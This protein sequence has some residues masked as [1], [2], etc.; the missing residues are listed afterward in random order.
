MPTRVLV[1]ACAWLQARLMMVLTS[2]VFDGRFAHVNRKFSVASIDGSE[3]HALM[4]ALHGGVGTSNWR[5]SLASIGLGG[6]A[7]MVPEGNTV[8]AAEL[9]ADVRPTVHHH[10][11]Y[12]HDDCFAP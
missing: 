5:E 7:D 8:A 10:L 1:R 12:T 6:E 4:R 2:P 11:S 9:C 3:A